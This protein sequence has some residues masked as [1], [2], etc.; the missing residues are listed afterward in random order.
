M[1]LEA[2]IFGI[3]AALAIGPIAILIINNGMNFGLQSAVRT[4][5]GAALADSTYA[6]C[7]FSFSAFVVYLFHQYK[8]VFSLFSSGLLV[9]LGS[10]IIWNALKIKTSRDQKDKAVKPIG[11]ITTYFLT[12]MSPLTILVFVSFAGKVEFSGTLFD[13]L[14]LSL[15]VFLGSLLMQMM[16]A[17]FGTSL[18]RYVTKPEMLQF[19]NIISGTGI[20]LF[21]LIGLR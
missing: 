12:L 19:L 5:V 2:F 17:F 3:T 16:L 10:W 8:T 18:K 4:G 13:I 11:L 20:I 7:A 15:A 14:Y 1:V 6:L 9:L 21:G